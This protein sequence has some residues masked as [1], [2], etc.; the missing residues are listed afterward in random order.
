MFYDDMTSQLMD[1]MLASELNQLSP[2]IVAA[3]SVT[4]T[5]LSV[6][7]TIPS[8]TMTVSS[9]TVGCLRLVPLCR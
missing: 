9:V 3:Y 1:D 7:V 2:V 5:P 8:V 4:V 6:S